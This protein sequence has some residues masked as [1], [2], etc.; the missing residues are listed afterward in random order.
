MMKINGSISN[1]YPTEGARFYEP[2]VE[3]IFLIDPLWEKVVFFLELAFDSKS[4]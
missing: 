1:F 4:V 2:P 3:A